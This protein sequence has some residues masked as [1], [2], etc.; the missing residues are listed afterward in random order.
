MKVYR[1]AA[2]TNNYQSIGIPDEYYKEYADMLRFD[3]EPKAS[4]WEQLSFP[5][6]HPELPC[7]DFYGFGNA[8]IVFTKKAYDVLYD[9]LSIYADFLPILFNGDTYYLLNTTNCINVL[10]DSKTEWNINDD[11]SRTSINKYKFL[12][13]RFTE[14]IIFKI[15]E[16]MNYDF[17]VLWGDDPEFDLK[18]IIKEEGLKGLVF[19]EVW[20]NG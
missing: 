5:V 4:F 12:P 20:S 10:D 1:L 19:E 6:L 3:C 18:E 11:G 16:D 14:D 9:Y 15:Q 7:G 13:H 2:D 17:T 8:G